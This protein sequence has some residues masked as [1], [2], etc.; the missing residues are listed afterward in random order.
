MDFNFRV[1]K[2]NI[3]IVDS[4][5]RRIVEKIYSDNPKEEAEKQALGYF[6]KGEGRP[7][8]IAT[9][10][11]KHPNRFGIETPTDFLIYYLA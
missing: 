3:F 5:E 2:A 1:M 8:H 7:K 6:E 10:T 9:P 11:E 4:I